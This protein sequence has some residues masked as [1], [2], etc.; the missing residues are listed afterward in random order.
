MMRDHYAYATLFL[1]PQTVP[2]MQPSI[3]PPSIILL[4]ISM[5]QSPALLSQ[6]VFLPT[7][8]PMMFL[9]LNYRPTLTSLTIQILTKHIWIKPNRQ[10]HCAIETR[11]SVNWLKFRSR[12]KRAVNP[13][14]TTAL[15]DLSESYLPLLK[16]EIFL[17]E[18]QEK[19]ARGSGLL[20]CHPAK[21]LL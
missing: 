21:L 1:L 12:L 17:R 15:L 11:I 18:L 8:D 19:K 5:H 20:S 14:M 16:L 9:S 6:H 4:G 13:G 10:K 3:L 2:V 7:P